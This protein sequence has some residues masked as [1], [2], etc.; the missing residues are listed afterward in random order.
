[1]ARRAEIWLLA[2]VLAVS[3][4]LSRPAAATQWLEVTVNGR[5]TGE[6]VAFEGAVDDLAAAAADLRRIGVNLP[7][8]DQ[9]QVQLRAV[10]GLQVTVDLANQ[11]IALD[12]D[13]ALLDGSLVTDINA[14]GTETEATAATG[15]MLGYDIFAEAASG[16]DAMVS[17]AGFGDLRAFSP[18]GVAHATFIGQ[19]GGDSPLLRLDSTIELDQPD[20]LTSIRLGDAITGSTTWTRSL[21]FGGIQVASNRGLQPGRSASTLP[22]IEGQ[23]AIPSVVDVYVNDGLRLSMPVD[24]G[25]FTIRDLPVVSGQGDVRV[26]VR[27]VL[28]R[29]SVQNIAFYADG[30][31]LPAGTLDYS[32]ELGFTRRRYAQDSFGYGR[33]AAVGTARY[34]LMEGDLTLEGHVEASAD[35]A[36]AGAGGY[37]ALG[38]FGVINGSLSGSTSSFGSGA[39]ATLGFSHQGEYVSVQ[40]QATL[41]S[42]DYADL[43]RLEGDGPIRR[44]FRINVGVPLG[45]LGGLGLAYAGIDR[46]G[47]GDAS[48]ATA[49]FSRRLF[50]DAFVQVTA[51]ADT[52]TGDAAFGVWLSVPLGGGV[53]GGVGVEHDRQGPSAR[54]SLSGRDLMGHEV[55]WRADLQQGELNRASLGAVYRASFADLRADLVGDE[56]TAA[57]RIGMAGSLVGMAGDAFASGPIEDSF[58]LIDTHGQAGIRVYRE[59]RPAGVTNADGLLLVT[60][61]QSYSANMVAIEPLD[62]AL[63]QNVDEP[64]RVVVPRSRSGVLVDFPVDTSAKALVTLLQTSGEP[65][66]LGA[67]VAMPAGDAL[68]GYDG[69]A[70]LAGLTARAD[71][72]V[73]W[74]GGGCRAVL[75][76][77]TIAARGGAPIVLPC[78]AID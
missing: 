59:N 15:L 14:S 72:D 56:R 1:M 75:E 32:A 16:S 57:A 76:Q 37:L 31:L 24:A 60:G 40:A 48:L 11:T 22:L 21:R 64:S 12:A 35:L 25:P 4:G 9:G 77:A 53:L 47:R 42:D 33:L 34:G 44:A 13:K 50:D 66:P 39:S 10:P 28:G 23:A 69:Q 68:V 29:E 63:E 55:D 70:Y 30:A 41:A 45:G 43:A 49:S 61:L 6:V 3:L 54:Q 74:A 18:W 5:A 52:R 73:R 26:V 67:R 36:L 62:F 8:A 71:L 27:D 7:V 20:T 51:T 46:G 58:A 65:V 78:T 19:S 17:V 38:E 2:A